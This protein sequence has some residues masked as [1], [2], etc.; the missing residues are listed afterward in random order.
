MTSPPNWP[1]PERPG[2]PMFPERDGLHV[3]MGP[4]DRV[5]ILVLWRSQTNHYLKGETRFTPEEVLD[6]RIAY[7]G[8]HLTPTQISELLAGERERV[9]AEAIPKILIGMAELPDRT[10]PEDA[11]DILTATAEEMEMIVTQNIRNLGAAP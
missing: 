4:Y 5:P 8:P 3:V 10:S 11:P 1:N 6:A 7:G 9:I 2:V